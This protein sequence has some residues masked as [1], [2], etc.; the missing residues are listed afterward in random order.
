[1]SC[2]QFAGIRAVIARKTLKSLNESTWNTLLMVLNEWGLVEGIN[3]KTNE[4]DGTLLFWNG[5]IIIKKEL[6][7]LPR[8]PSFQRLG[9]SE[10]TIAF[11]DEVGEISEKGVE[12]LYSRLRWR[13]AETFKVP[14]MLLSTNPVPNW[15]RDRFVQDRY[16]NPVKLRKHDAYIPFSVFDNPKDDFVQIYSQSLAGMRDQMEV[17]S[18]LS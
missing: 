8:D 15:V 16:G 1:M 18:C 3:Y 14:K 17:Q 12:V 4:K 6:E 9:S 5:S 13:V 2:I 10:F 11:I 7:L